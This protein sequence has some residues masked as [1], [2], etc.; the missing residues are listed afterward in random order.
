MAK[1]AG[2]LVGKLHKLLA[3]LDYRPT[4]DLKG[5][6][7]TPA[8]LAKLDQV[9]DQLSA[10]GQALAQQ[11]LT[12]APKYFISPE[13]Q[14]NQVI[15]GDLK[16]S[17]LVFDNDQHAI[18]IIDFDTIIYK[19]RAIDLGDAL[20][21]WC[22]TSTEDD[23]AA[24]FDMQLFTAAETAYRENFDANLNETAINLKATKLIALE[25]AARFLTDV[26][27]DNYFSFDDKRFPT[28]KA[29]NWARA[30]AQFNL[31]QSI[32]I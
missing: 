22:N 29:H 17:N 7:D 16:I 26:V 23:P 2:A 28:R 14:A 18:G 10:D 25:L 13:E 11:I 4:A 6:H 20:R 8:V 32:S 3:Q 30:Q 1:E 9:V 19:P 27:T 24:S 21:S 15:H 5:F 12:E 31:A